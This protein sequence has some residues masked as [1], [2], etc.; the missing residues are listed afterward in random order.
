M[1]RYTCLLLPT[2]TE[3]LFVMKLNFVMRF[4]AIWLFAASYITVNARLTFTEKL[5]KKNAVVLKQDETIDFLIDGRK[6]DAKS[7]A[8]KAVVSKETIV[9]CGN[10]VDQMT[11][12]QP[13]VEKITLPIDSKHSSSS[14]SKGFHYAQGYRLKFFTGSGTREGKEQAQLKGKEFKRHFPHA[15]VYMHFVSPNWICTAGDFTTQAE[16]HEFIKEVKKDATF[17]LSEV[18]V[19][20]SKVKIHNY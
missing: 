11:K 15:S 16:V 13:K 3:I 7:L 9:P 1:K 5:R 8:N 19:V 14:S 17:H 6:P 20:K 4:I 10:V 12:P 2:L 18:N